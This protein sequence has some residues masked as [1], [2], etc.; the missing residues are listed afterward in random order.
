MQLARASAVVSVVIPCLNEQ[1]AIASVVRDVLDQGVDEVIVVDNGSRDATAK[2]ARDAGAR[3][4]PE[5]RRG[6]GRACAA[7]VAGIRADAEIVCFLDGDGSDV[8]R[9]LGDVVGPVARGK[10]DFVMGS[11]LRGQR[12]SGSM[13]LQQLVA[14]WLA[15]QLLRVVYG[16][17]FTDMSPFRA[18]RVDQLR[19]LGMTEKT[20]GW[21]LEMQMRAAAA[22]LRIREVPV[23]HRRRRGGVSKVSGNLT[24][25]FSAAWRITTTF[26]RLAC[27]LRGMQ[28]GHDLS[29]PRQEERT[30]QKRKD[31][32]LHPRIV[33]ITHWTWALGVL[34]LIASGL[35]IYNSEPLF[36]FYFPTWVTIG[37]SLEAANKVHND[38][39]LAGALLW[40]F[41]AMWLL[42]TSLV[43]FLVYGFRS[44]HFRR[45]YLPITVPE[46]LGN[47]TDFF[48]GNLAHDIGVRNAVQ[49]LLYAFA[50]TAMTL[51]VLSGLVLWKPVQFHELGLIMGQY[52]G[53]R[54]VH[55][56]GM[57]GIVLFLV[58]HI[59]LTLLVPKVLLPM[60]T[61]REPHSPAA[62]EAS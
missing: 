21:N 51:M 30:V 49:K 41:T 34:I 31:V 15:G 61:G 52:E 59:A 43:V 6:Y 57:I 27:A 56:F 36:D 17:R 12:E 9:F 19:R 55:F 60:I 20:Y 2:R 29:T 1:V 5:P 10:A 33:R 58:V 40:H 8:P 25:G 53:A 32:E 26:L 50:L 22:G 16:V 47:I 38:W 23:D 45:K 3:V 46:V 11:R 35:R 24:A 62:P 48:K 7:G 28:D 18:M 37:G 4:V 39:G 13:T 42:F 14:G 54:Y 44:G